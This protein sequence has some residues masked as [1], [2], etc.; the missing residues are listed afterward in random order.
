MSL[1]TITGRLGRDAELK[2]TSGGTKVL[3]FSIA[4]DIGRGDK[5]RTQWINCALFGDRAEK[6]GR[7]LTK[8]TLVECHG[9]PSA[10]AWKNK[11]G[12]PQAALELTVNEVKMHGGG[13]KDDEPVADRGRATR[14]DDEDSDIPF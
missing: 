2:T 9:V 13:K 6:L 14:R 10:R 3:S 5:K 4:D 7:Y 1:M 12:E 8:G 11:D